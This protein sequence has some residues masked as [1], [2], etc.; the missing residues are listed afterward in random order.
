MYEFWPPPIFCLFVFST[1][2]CFSKYCALNDFNVGVFQKMKRR[3][4]LDSWFNCNGFFG[5]FCTLWY[6]EIHICQVSFDAVLSYLR[7]TFMKISWMCFT[8]PESRFS[9]H[10]S[11]Y[12]LISPTSDM[13]GQR[14]LSSSVPCPMSLCISL[15]IRCLLEMAPVCYEIQRNQ[16][17]RIG[18]ELSAKEANTNDPGYCKNTCRS[19]KN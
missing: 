14:F 8:G 4:Q 17:D 15:H 5:H 2:M 9:R 6:T 16:L 3:A 7:T 11:A 13:P 12:V 18:L 1:K 19:C 10:V